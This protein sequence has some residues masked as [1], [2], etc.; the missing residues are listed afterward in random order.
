ME[1][2]RVSAKEYVAYFTHTFHVFNT[3]E[4][5]ELNSDKCKKLHYLFFV[6]KKVRLGIILGER[7]NMLLSP[8]SAPFGGFS[9]I[10]SD[11]RLEYIE[12]AIELLEKYAFGNNLS[13]KIT[14]PPSIYDSCFISK[15]VALFMRS[16]FQVQYVDLNY[17]FETE[18][19]A[20]YEQ[21]IDRS[22]RKNL[23]HSFKQEF[24]FRHLT[25]VDP[26]V[27]KRVYEIIRANR[28]GKGY[29]LR[30]TLQNV[31]DTIQIIKADFFVLSYG[32]K[33]IA[34]AQVFHVAE[35]VVQVIYWGDIPGYAELRAMNFLAYRIFEYY[36]STGVKIVDIGPSSENGIPNYGLCEFKENIGCSVTLKYTYKLES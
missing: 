8:F 30:M 27:V 20:D 25:P 14:L 32:E 4:F 23:H 35:N 7:E 17:H 6:N 21:R 5:T 26:T 24:S 1:L 16:R 10:K 36:A 15:Q 19:F 34:A 13:V 29:P 12:E 2:N 33:D 22:A 9:F 3:E 28:E 18:Y 11:I 31:L